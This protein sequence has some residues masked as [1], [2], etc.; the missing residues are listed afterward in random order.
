MARPDETVEKLVARP[1]RQYLTLPRA[2][3][4]QV[5][6]GIDFGWIER[7]ELSKPEFDL[8][9]PPALATLAREEITG[10]RFVPEF[11]RAFG[12]EMTDLREQLDEAVI[13]ALYT[14]ME[15]ADD[16]LFPPNSDEDDDN[17]V[18]YDDDVPPTRSERLKAIGNLLK[19]NLN[20]PMARTLALRVRALQKAELLKD[21]PAATTI[22]G[23]MI[24]NHEVFRSAGARQTLNI[25]SEIKKAINDFI[26]DRSDIRGNIFSFFKSSTT[27]PAGYAEEA[28]RR[29]AAIQ[30]LVLDLFDDISPEV[31][32]EFQAASGE[33]SEG[34]RESTQNHDRLRP[35]NTFKAAFNN[36]LRAYAQLKDGK[37]SHFG[38]VL[39][40]SDG[41]LETLGVGFITEAI[42]AAEEFT[43]SDGKALHLFFP[44]ISE[45]GVLPF[46]SA[47]GKG[48]ELMTSSNL[49]GDKMTVLH[50][51]MEF[52]AN[53]TREIFNMMRAIDLR[54]RTESPEDRHADLKRE[55]RYGMVTS[56]LTVN[57]SLMS[58]LI[59]QNSLMQSLWEGL[60]EDPRTF[61]KNK[62]LTSDLAFAAH[63]DLQM[64]ASIAAAFQD[65]LALVNAA[66]GEK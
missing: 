15:G 18:D 64:L 37:D 33:F 63:Y 65:S 49:L 58:I 62:K 8:D 38:T 45:F 17:D 42:D 7:L 21:S 55:M 10:Q 39:R 52:L 40:T 9:Q 60:A 11:P 24:G 66:F 13:I 48:D 41:S 59:Q 19:Q 23:L 51:Q 29:N 35:L 43:G 20:D 16:Y 61:V 26:S 1:K 30:K 2:N 32:D 3:S 25:P 27:D 28:K 44:R 57:L 5:A 36:G 46:V 6:Y 31:L 50:T 12:E 54:H 22:T 34:F 56:L 53:M 47:E 14:G 4:D